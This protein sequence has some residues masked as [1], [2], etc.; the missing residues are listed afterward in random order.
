MSEVVHPPKARSSVCK[1]IFL[2]KHIKVWGSL[3]ISVIESRWAVNTSRHSIQCL[4]LWAHFKGK[5][6][7][8]LVKTSIHEGDAS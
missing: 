4:Q 8:Q 5:S 6:T 7:S 2:T 1:L 3:C